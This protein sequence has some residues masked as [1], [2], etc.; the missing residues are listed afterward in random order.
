MQSKLR[1]QILLD[2][3]KRAFLTAAGELAYSEV[4]AAI[5]PYND[6]GD[7]ARSFAIFQTEDTVSVFSDEMSAIVLDQGRAPGAKQ[8][9]TSQLEAWGGRHGFDSIE[10]LF[11]LARVIKRRGIR[12]R[13]YMAVAI[14]KVEAKTPNLLTNIAAAKVE[15]AWG[16]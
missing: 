9:S 16:R 3:A 12:S 11:A 6:T 1:P 14:A 13:N 15:M 8:P 10:S 4:L 7:T 2:P 5:S